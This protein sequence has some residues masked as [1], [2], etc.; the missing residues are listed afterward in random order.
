[1]GENPR[2]TP[3]KAFCKARSLAA[4]S[5]R[6]RD[7]GQNGLS[8]LA[9]PKTSSAAMNDAAEWDFFPAFSGISPVHAVNH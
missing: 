4:C 3:F 9:L 8:R 6:R 7:K 2:P 5:P 1:M